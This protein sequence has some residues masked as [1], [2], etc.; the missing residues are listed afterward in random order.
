MALSQRKVEEN[1][2]LA[3]T[4]QYTAPYDISSFS[5]VS[6]TVKSNNVAT[7]GTMSLQ[8]CNFASTVNADWTDIPA[9]T[10]PA[11]V[12]LVASGSATISTY[13]GVH[14]GFVRLKIVLSAGADTDYAIFTLAKDF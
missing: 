8:F 13:S 14:A 5:G 6:Y 11:S 12:A 2:T 4:T 7:N 1:Y 10:A 9:T 3:N